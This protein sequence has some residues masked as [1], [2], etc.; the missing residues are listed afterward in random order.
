MQTITVE[1]LTPSAFSPFG[2]ELFFY[3]ASSRITAINADGDFLMFMW[4][5]GQAGNCIFHHPSE[6]LLVGGLDTFTSQ[7][8]R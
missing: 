3:H 5:S 4:E 7:V 8:R 6:P 1:R 2:E